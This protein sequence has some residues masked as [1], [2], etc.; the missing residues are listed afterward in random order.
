MPRV[1]ITGGAGLIGSTLTDLLLA[2]RPDV[3][4]VTVLDDLSRGLPSNLDGARGDD[5]FRFVEGDVRD[6]ELVDELVAGADVIFHMAAIRIT[7]CVSEPRLANDILAN[8][9]FNVVESAAR[10]SATKVV[11]SSSASVYGTATTFPTPEDHHPWDNRTLY[12]AAKAYGEGVLASSL[13]SQGLSY[14]ALRYFNVY[15]P[16]MDTE[17]RYTE[18]MIRWLEALA[19]E[20]PLRI[21]GDGSASM[22]FVHVEDVARANVLALDAP[23]GGFV[24][25]IGTGAE[26]SLLELAHLL[27]DVA[28]VRAQ[29]I[30]GPARPGASVSR[31]RADTSA[32]AEQLGFVASKDLRTGLGELATWWTEQRRPVP[33]GGA[34]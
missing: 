32:A 9:T 11:F 3:T 15:G 19:E 14:V 21:D 4:A 8:G 29:V 22:D 34:S 17:G 6:E 5:R 1:L 33:A 26:T 20:R 28:G 31:R 16:R 2:S 12:G 10:H 30:H 13:E 24:Y 7:R 25:N 27:G 18:V 23:P